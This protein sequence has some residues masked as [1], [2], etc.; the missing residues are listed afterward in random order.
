MAPVT[1]TPLTPFEA[2]LVLGL[3]P[4]GTRI[5]RARY[6]RHHAYPCPIR[7]EVAL[8]SGRPWSFV[9][10]SIRQPRGHLER[11][12]ALYPLLAHLGL[13]VPALLAGPHRDP[14]DPAGRPRIVVSLLAGDNLQRLADCGGGSLTR[15]RDLVVEAVLTLHGLTRAVRAD[16]A[17]RVV[18]AGG[19]AHHLDTVIR[20]RGPWRETPVFREACRRLAPV[21]RRIRD[22]LVFSNGDYQ[23][24]NFLAS[25]CHL[26]GFL[27]FEFAWFEDPLYGFAK[28]PIY[29]LAP[30]N[31]AGMVEAFLKRSGYS[32]GDFAP[33]LALGCL[34]TLN[35][36]IPVAA[37]SSRYRTHVLRLLTSSLHA[38]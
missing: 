28:Y 2:R 36:E 7:V 15:A 23:P 6:F 3:A 24:A 19:L 1:L 32:R 29:D 14:S 4:R 27:D 33:R 20:Q 25:G 13:P 37:G 8:P 21:L 30:L 12:V 9:V 22:P 16:P 10:R 17:A 18:P 31:R 11:E 34:A 5:I 38:L 26:S 35:R